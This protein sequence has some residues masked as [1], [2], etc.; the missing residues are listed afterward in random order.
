M[1][2]T[3]LYR[4]LLQL[5]AAISLVNC[6][7][8]LSGRQSAPSVHVEQRDNIEL[9]CETAFD[10][11]TI[12]H[13][14]QDTGSE[15]ETVLGIRSNGEPVRVIVFADVAGYRRKLERQ[16]P[17]SRTRTAV[18][19][20]KDGVSY[21]YTFQSRTLITDIRHELTHALLHQNLP[22]LPLWLD[23]GL[24]EY[25]ED[26]QE[27]R[28]TTH[29]ARTVR[30]RA[31]VGLVTPLKTLEAVQ[32]AGDMDDDDYRDSWAWVSF[33]L[34]ESPDSRKLLRSYLQDIRSGQKPK[35][36]S[37]LTETQFPK[38]R[39]RILAFLRK[40]TRLSDSPDPDGNSSFEGSRCH[41]AENA[42]ID[43]R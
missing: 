23:E 5:V 16:F 22:F 32:R 19:V 26:T 15:L 31:A 10:T 27:I 42:D 2:R 37:E 38:C 9:I 17:E 7:E 30:W 35:P 25:F 3:S 39:S 24:A 18:F 4:P 11:W 20:R 33:L 43:G 8:L 21:L 1:K 28:F 36:F 41:S 12:W 14:I 34:N 13:H 40:P 6:A 29:R